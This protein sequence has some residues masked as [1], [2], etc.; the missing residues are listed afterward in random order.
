MRNRLI[1]LFAAS[2]ILFCCI[3]AFSEP[4]PIWLSVDASDAAR[5]ILHSRLVIPARPGR[6]TLVYPKWIPGEHGPTGPIV[7]LAGLK[8]SAA[9]MKLA[10]ANQRRWTPEILRAAVKSAMTNAVPIE[11]LLENND[12]FQTCKLDYHE[13]EKYPCLERD[14]TRPDLLADILKP[15]GPVG[16]GTAK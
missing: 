4:A 12:Y 2:C 9:G 1:R 8:I 14:V 3:P 7:D 16:G 13:G 6:L 10:A 5:N 15:R 11:L